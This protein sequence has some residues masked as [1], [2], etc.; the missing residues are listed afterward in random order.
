MIDCS[1]ELASY[2]CGTASFYLGEIFTDEPAIVLFVQIPG[3]ELARR[4]K[5]NLDGLDPKLLERRIQLLADVTA[6]TVEEVLG[7]PPSF[8][9]HFVSRSLTRHFP[10]GDHLL[11]PRAGL[12]ELLLLCFH[13]DASSL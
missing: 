11:N 3:N 4:G 9:N 12:V 5:S 13:S 10:L 6:G 7:V 8:G 1:M 2:R